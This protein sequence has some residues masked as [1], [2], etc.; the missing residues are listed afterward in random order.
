MIAM[1]TITSIV[2]ATR[3]QPPVGLAEVND[4]LPDQGGLGA[5]VR[6]TFLDPAGPLYNARHDHLRGATI[7][8][9]WTSAEA[10]KR[11]RYIAGEAQLVR[12]QQATWSS[13]RS[14]WQIRQWFGGEPDAIITLSAPF[15][16]SA[17][18]MTFC[19][20]V[21]H[22][23]CH[24]AQ[25]CDGFGE[26]RFDAE[27]RPVLTTIAHDVEQF[28]DVVERYGAVAAG[29]EKMVRAAAAGPTIGAAQM[30]LACGNCG[31]IAA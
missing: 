20:L 27:G 1:A 17:D 19:A 21:E 22:E 16:Q 18:D 2:R 9:L 5:W 15:C 30:T 3:P 11:N 23:L 7:G 26:P 31:R 24:I 25:D 8:W 4:F 10:R 12:P 28:D 14:M 13:A 29:V 6:D